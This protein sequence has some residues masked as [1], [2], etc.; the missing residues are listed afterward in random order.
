MWVERTIVER[1]EHSLQAGEVSASGWNNQRR[2]HQLSVELLRL[3]EVVGPF[4]PPFR[5]G[6]QVLDF[7]LF[8]Q[9]HHLRTQIPSETEV[10]YFF[11][12]RY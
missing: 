9:V 5:N 12:E 8:Q 4:T 3:N 7:F 1:G 6:R 11:S 10:G 2:V